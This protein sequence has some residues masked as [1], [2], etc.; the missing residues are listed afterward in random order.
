MLAGDQRGGGH[1]IL[2]VFALARV[3]FL[4]GTYLT[5]QPVSA[6]VAHHACFS[7]FIKHIRLQQLTIQMFCQ[8]LCNWLDVRALHQVAQV[9]ALWRAVP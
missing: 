9:I 3:V 7:L 8:L 5:I 6:K 4:K 1:V 2:V